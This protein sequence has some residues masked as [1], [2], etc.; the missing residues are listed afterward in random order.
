MESQPPREEPKPTLD[1]GR[2]PKP[3]VPTYR[4]VLA[5]ALICGGTPFLVVAA[6]QPQ[7]VARLDITMPGLGL[8]MW[9]VV[10]R[11]QHIR[12]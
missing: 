2:P 3:L 10:I 11:F 8:I 12:F 6:L 4:K 5:W 1:Y 7:P 9:G